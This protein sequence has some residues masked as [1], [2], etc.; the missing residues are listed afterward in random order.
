[1]SVKYFSQYGDEEILEFNS[2][3]RV[4]HSSIH[5]PL[6]YNGEVIDYLH[7]C[8]II[9]LGDH[10]SLNGVHVPIDTTID[11]V[12]ETLRLRKNSRIHF[13]FSSIFFF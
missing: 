11:Y 7:Y 5:P 12:I 13:D 6:N 1:M 4:I 3:K 2:S 8:N 10:L 9:N